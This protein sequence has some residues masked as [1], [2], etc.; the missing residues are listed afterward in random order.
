[1][2]QPGG[3]AADISRHGRGESPQRADAAGVQHGAPIPFTGGIQTPELAFYKSQKQNSFAK[4]AMLACSENSGSHFYSSGPLDGKA[5]NDHYNLLFVSWFRSD[6]H[7][8][9]KVRMKGI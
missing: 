9:S 7:E 2:T 6:I 8:K 3:Y 1:V 5:Y 4:I